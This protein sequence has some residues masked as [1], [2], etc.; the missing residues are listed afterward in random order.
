[1]IGKGPLLTWYPSDPNCG[2]AFNAA[3]DDTVG[4]AL[5]GCGQTN[6]T[7]AAVRPSTSP[8]CS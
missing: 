6:P 5:R 4:G 3:V 8:T 7:N 1:M 2:A